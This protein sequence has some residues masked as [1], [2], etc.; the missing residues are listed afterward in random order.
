MKVKELPI[1]IY[2]TADISEAMLRT[3]VEV[4]YDKLLMTYVNMLA[5]DSQVP[6]YY[7]DGVLTYLGEVAREENL[8]P[9][10]K[11]VAVSLNEGKISNVEIEGYNP[12]QA[13]IMPIDEYYRIAA[14]GEGILPNHLR[15]IFTYDDEVI[16]YAA[17]VGD[18][19]CFLYRHGLNKKSMF[20]RFGNWLKQLFS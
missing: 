7:S 11:L 2:H 5:L 6:I 18:T 1:L 17:F 10:I 15:G 12:L 3:T 9:M 14:Q 16:C 13:V 19:P 20:T 4:V 8:V